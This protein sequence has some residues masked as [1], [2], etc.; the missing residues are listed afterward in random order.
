MQS[1][2]EEMQVKEFFESMIVSKN[3][4]IASGVTPIG[5]ADRVP[6]EV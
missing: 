3:P 4:T 2:I 1:Q 6:D 5:S